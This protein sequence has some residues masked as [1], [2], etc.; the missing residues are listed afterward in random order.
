M[1][2]S[3]I[4]ITVQGESEEVPA[5]GFVEAVSNSLEVLSELDS[6]ISQKR[7]GTL[8][9]IIGSLK[10]ESPAVVTLRAVPVSDEVD[11]GAEVAQSYVHGLEILQ[12]GKSLPP[13]FSE[14]A[15][16]AVKRLGRIR[17]GVK[18]IKIQHRKEVI[19]ITERLAVNIDDLISRTSESVGSFEGTLEMV[20]IHS[21]KYFRVYEPVHGRG[22]VCYF[23][24]D[25]L[26]VVKSSLGDRV[27][28]SGRLRSDRLG[29]PETITVTDLRVLPEEERLPRPSEL[30]GLVKGMTAGEKAE[31]YLRKLRGDE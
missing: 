1:P 11:V 29:K 28:V 24:P 8:R 4:I 9:W 30:R 27:A 18:T 7:A 16:N 13:M 20:T 6:A 10:Y 21:Q 17:E 31:E 2:A 12:G 5:R 25:L 15:L 26:E 22:I 19:Q 14:T 23:P 3:E